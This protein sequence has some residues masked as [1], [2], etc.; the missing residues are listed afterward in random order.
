[1]DAVV[2]ERPTVEA[3]APSLLRLNVAT[4]GVLV[5]RD[6]RRFFRQLSRVVGALV[7]PLIFWLVIG[8]GLSGSFRMQGADGVGYVQYFYPGIVMLVVLFTSIFTTMSVIEDRHKGF[9]QAVL[10][11]PASRAALVL[12]KTLG[13]VAIALV[14]A[15]IF[16]ALAPLAGFDVRVIEWPLL[17]ALLLLI[18]IGLSSMGF[19]IAWWL[20]STQ[21]YHIVMSVL[22]I[23]LWIVSGAMFP[24]TGGPRWIA[25]VGRA[26]PMA[27]AVAGVRRALYGGVAPGR[28]DSTAALELGVT[29]AF[30]VAMVLVAVAV[31]SRRGD[32]P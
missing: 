9:L 1:M 22:L 14:Q 10:V 11:A 28:S 6:L 24:M 4:V 29:L 31:C 2:A 23:P 5:S 26:N 32:K 20:D 13:G 30:A 16:L 3:E 12:G 18:G 17:F 7:Q 25:V 15:A 27:Y 19:A 8:S 21:G